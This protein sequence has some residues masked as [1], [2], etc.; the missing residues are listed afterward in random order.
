MVFSGT[1]LARAGKPLAV[2]LF[3]VKFSPTKDLS[4]IGD[5]FS[6]LTLTASVLKDDTRQGTD[7]S[8]FCEIKMVEE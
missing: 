8:A 4:F 3:R 7:I 2:D 6:G 5:D 1:N